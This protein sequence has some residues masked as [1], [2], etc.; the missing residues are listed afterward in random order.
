MA[1]LV[2]VLLLPIFFLVFSFLYDPYGMEDFLSVGGKNSAF[3]LLMLT[4]IMMGVLALSRLIFYLLHKHIDFLWWQYLLWCIGEVVVNSLFMALYVALFYG[5]EMLYFSVLS[6]CLKYAFTIL[7]YPYIIFTLIQICSNYEEYIKTASQPQAIDDSLAKFYDEHHR[8]KL[9]INPAAVLF[10]SAEMNYIN[11][12]YI[13][14][15]KPKEFMIRNSMKSVE[16]VATKHGLVRCHRSYYV[17][18]R[19]VKLLSRAKDGLIQAELN[20]D[21][22]GLIPVSKQYYDRLANLL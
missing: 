12:H 3:H 17:N 21:G 19:H 20:R 10:I 14:N 7:V 4:S 16:T 1:H 8:L 11:V 6:V 2:Y 15:D 5:Q 22:L 9:T 13:E 18:P